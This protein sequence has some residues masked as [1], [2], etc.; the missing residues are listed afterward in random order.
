MVDRDRGHDG[1][2]DSWSTANDIGSECDVWLEPAIAE[3]LAAQEHA[4]RD[5]IPNGKRQPRI[6][7]CGR[8]VPLV[9][10][11]NHRYR[12]ADYR[13]V[14]LSLAQEPYGLIGLLLRA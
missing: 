7:H 2:G 13:A 14:Y 10:A 11:F 6:A 9:E 4:G 5:R 8:H 12:K 1:I 3:G